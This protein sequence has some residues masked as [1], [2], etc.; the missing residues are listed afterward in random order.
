[1]RWWLELERGR[2]RLERVAYRWW[3]L[4]VVVRWWR[5]EL[6]ARCGGGLR[7]KWE[8]RCGGGLSWSVELAAA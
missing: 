5:L 8:A 2:R 3:M 4:E 1:M 7:W 6:V